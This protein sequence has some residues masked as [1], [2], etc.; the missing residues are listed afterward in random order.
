MVK[1]KE[2]SLSERAKQLRLAI[3]DF[4]NI[5]DFSNKIIAKY[6]GQLTEVEKELREDKEK[7]EEN[8]K[9]FQ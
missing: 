6:E 1:G 8:K 3:I 9:K 5:R 4:K 7:K 2:I